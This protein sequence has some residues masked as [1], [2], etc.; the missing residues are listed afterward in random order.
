M[1]TVIASALNRE[2]MRNALLVLI[3]LWAVL[4]SG[5]FSIYLAQA[6]TGQLP[7]S[8]VVTLALLK[9]VGFAVFAMP[10]AWFV[11]ILM[12]LGRWNNDLEAVALAAAGFGPFNYLRILLPSAML[13]AL[14]A[15]ALALYIVPESIHYG[16][17]LKAEASQRADIKLWRAGRFMSLQKG[18]L[19]LFADALSEDRSAMLN[20]FVEFNDGQQQMLISADR[21]VRYQDENGNRFVVLKNGI[22]YDGKPGHADYRE[23]Q[24]EEYGIRIGESEPAAFRWAGVASRNLFGNAKLPATAELQE[25][26]SRPISVLVLTLTA[27]ILARFMPGRGYY[28]S[29]IAGILIFVL[30]F[31]LLG[32]IRSDMAEG[33]IPV[34]PGL[35]WVHIVPIIAAIIID[36]LLRWRLWNKG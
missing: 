23:M 27:I 9:S 13:I 6:A 15:A 4:L 34:L 25:R 3:V 35:W 33:K 12:T 28:T 7:A 16:H 5:R 30:Y 26:I 29:M 14:I 31:N 19:L 17:K 8:M 2:V 18:K 36:R 22:R 24:F 32:V 1:N 21:A 10:V 11:A 20:V